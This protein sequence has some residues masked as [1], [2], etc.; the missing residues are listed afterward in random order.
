M[1]KYIV[2][3]TAVILLVAGL[4][5]FMAAE[6]KIAESPAKIISKMTLEEKVGQIIIGS[7]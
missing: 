1:A 5:K 4:L 6:Q 7:F 2:A 3:L